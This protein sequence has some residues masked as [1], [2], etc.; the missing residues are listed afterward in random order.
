M[1]RGSKYWRQP[2]GKPGQKKK[3]KPIPQEQPRIHQG[4][5]GKSENRRKNN[6]GP[7]GPKAKMVP[8]GPKSLI[9]RKFEDLRGQVFRQRTNQRT[10]P[11]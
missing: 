4:G 6:C 8:R 5:I 10:W 1:P 2:E 11:P 3:P 7:F 9:N